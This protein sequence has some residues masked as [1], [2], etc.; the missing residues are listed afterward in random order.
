MFASIARNV[1]NYV[2]EIIILG[3]VFVLLVAGGFVMKI[4]KLFRK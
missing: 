1:A 4:W 3:F 2:A